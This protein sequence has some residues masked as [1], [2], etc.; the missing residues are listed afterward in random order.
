[1]LPQSSMP[2]ARAVLIPLD[3]FQRVRTSLFP[4]FPSQLPR[5][6]WEL[7]ASP[8]QFVI[9]CFVAAMTGAC[10]GIE[11]IDK[12]LGD[13]GV[14][15]AETIADGTQ[16]PIE[17]VRG[18]LD[19]LCQRGFLTQHDQGYCWRFAYEAAQQA[20]VGA[21]KQSQLWAPRVGSQLEALIKKYGQ[22]CLACGR[23]DQLSVDHV[24]P[25]AKGGGGSLANLQLLCLPC[26]MRKH[27]GSTDYR[28]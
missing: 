14:I 16:M 27:T 6:V 2:S 9:G 17:E 3:E 20:A 23:A 15:S 25:K 12:Y 7:I 26:N 19:V 24:I 22:S 21:A 8:P 13:F 28:P 11:E 18:H 10:H 4:E 1:M 5:Y